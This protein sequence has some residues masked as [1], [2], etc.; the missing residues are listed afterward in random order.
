[1]VTEGRL[2]NVDVE[3]GLH[4]FEAVAEDFHD[5]QA[6]GVTQGGQDRRQLDRFDRRMLDG[7]HA[8]TLPA[9]IDDDRGML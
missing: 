1:V 9:I 4:V 6:Y 8:N 5:A 3:V 7:A 2:A